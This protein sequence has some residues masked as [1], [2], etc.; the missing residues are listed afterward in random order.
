MNINKR[1]VKHF[2]LSH[3]VYLF[4][5]RREELLFFAFR[6]FQNPPGLNS[7][8]IKMPQVYLTNM[9]EPISL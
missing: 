5:G 7:G 3:Q 9:H 8:I 6:A 2:F 1:K 4:S